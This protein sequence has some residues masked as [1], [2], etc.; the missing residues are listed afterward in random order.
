MG[1]KHG[2]IKIAFGE[3]VGERTQVEFVVDGEVVD[4]N[5]V[6]SA[7]VARRGACA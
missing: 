2:K 7:C 4:G 5:I 3:L 6:D 1:T